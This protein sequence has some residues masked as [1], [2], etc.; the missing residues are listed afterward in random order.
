MPFAIPECSHLP[1][2]IIDGCLVNAKTQPINPHAQRLLAAA[3]KTTKAPP[4]AEAKAKSKA[5]AKAKATAQSSKPGKSKGKGKDGK[6]KG[7]GKGKDEKKKKKG[8]EK[9]DTPKNTRKEAEMTEYSIAKKQ[10]MEDP[11]N[12]DWKQI[13]CAI[14]V[15]T[16]TL[17]SDLEAFTSNGPSFNSGLLSNAARCRKVCTVS[18]LN[19]TWVSQTWPNV[20]VVIRFKN[21]FQVPKNKVETKR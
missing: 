17:T 18:A 13:Y 20:C 19:A 5:S 6:G 10:F 9:L 12:L 3:A 2:N 16:C 14:I 7:K 21:V 8:E 15:S 4:G 11:W 1:R